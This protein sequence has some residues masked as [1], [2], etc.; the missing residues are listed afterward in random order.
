MLVLT[1]H[2][3]EDLPFSKLSQKGSLFGIDSSL[4]F[5]V[6]RSA[7]VVLKKK[8]VILKIS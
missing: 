7:W 1:R 3:L 6:K 4:N 2:E 8:N 5:H